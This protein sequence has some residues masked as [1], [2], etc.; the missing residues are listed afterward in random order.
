MVSVAGVDA[1]DGAARENQCRTD[2]VSTDRP[3][4]RQVT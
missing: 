1:G 3:V 4:P 2:G